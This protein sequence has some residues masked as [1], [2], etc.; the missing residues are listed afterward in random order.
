ME[1]FARRLFE[2]MAERGLSQSDLARK[3]WGET[4]D[5]KGYPVA[6]NRDRI[7]NYLRGRSYPE[8]ANLKLLAEALEVSV[9]DIIPGANLPPVDQQGLKSTRTPDVTVETLPSKA[10]EPAQALLTVRKVLPMS[11]VVQVLGLIHQ[12]EK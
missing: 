7:G 1:A 6:R 10:G 9:E 11:V 4:K 3:I 8:Q 12:E 5:T 2:L